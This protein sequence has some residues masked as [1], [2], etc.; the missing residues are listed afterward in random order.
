MSTPVKGCVPA[1]DFMDE[2]LSSQDDHI[3][4]F[5]Q[6]RSFFDKVTESESSSSSDA[7]REP[8]YLVYEPALMLLLT[9][10]RFCGNYSNTITKTVI[11]SLLEVSTL[12]KHCLKT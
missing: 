3:I 1:P 7:A 5:E 6:S 12:C 11:G 2:S 4:S 10:C 8:Y 9:M